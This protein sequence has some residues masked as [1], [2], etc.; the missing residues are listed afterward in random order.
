MAPAC[1][2]DLQRAC[3]A[4]VGSDVLFVVGRVRPEQLRTMRPSYINAILIQRGG[5][6]VPG[7]C[8]E[9][10]RRGLT[11][12]PECR[13]AL[14]HFGDAYGNCK[15]RDHGIRCSGGSPP[16]DSGRVVELSDSDD[17]YDDDDDSIRG[18]SRRTRGSG[19]QLALPAPGHAGNPIEID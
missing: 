1:H 14:G 16:G 2:N 13:R 6:L 4:L 7:G 9:C 5:T 8:G 12:F 3:L 17:E 18:P 11:P 10:Q 19:G 15:W